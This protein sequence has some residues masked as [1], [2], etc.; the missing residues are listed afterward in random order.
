MN[1][2][3]KIFVH[4]VLLLWFQFHL[5]LFTYFIYDNFEN[6]LKLISMSFNFINNPLLILITITK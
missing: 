4:T 1:Q 5:F 3:K 2:K 6:V